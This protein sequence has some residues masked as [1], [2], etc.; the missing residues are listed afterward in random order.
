VVVLAGAD[1]PSP[2]VGVPRVTIDGATLDDP[3]EAVESLHRSWSDR[4]PVV[5]DLGVD[6]ADL[7][8]PVDHRVEPWRVDPGFEPWLDQLHFLVWANNYDARGGEPVWWWGRK[9]VEVG[10]TTTGTADVTLPDGTP[11]WVDGGPRTSRPLTDLAVVHAETVEAGR[12]DRVPAPATP[13][14]ALDPEQLAA[15]DHDSGPARVIA[16]A[17]SGKTRVLT[18]RLRHLIA[19]RGYETGGVLAVAYNKQAQLEMAARTAGLGARIQTLNAWGYS[20]VARILG[21][22]PEVIDERAVRAIVEGLVPR[23]ARRVNTD[24]Y[25]RYLEGLSLI[26]LGLRPPAQVEAEFGD[27]P[28]LADAFGPYRAALRSRGVVDFDEQVYLAVESLL[29][30]GTLRRSL[31]AEHRHL[32]VDEFQD[33]TPAHV[34]LVRLLSCPGYDVFAVGDDDQTIYSHAGADPRFLVDFD[35]FFPAATHHALEVN[36]RCPRAVTEGAG[37]LLGYNTVRVDKVIRP[38]RAVA[39]AVTGLDV[40]GH[41]P[42]QGAAAVAS[43]VAGWQG[44]GAVTDGMAVLARVQSLLLGPHVALTDAGVPVDSIVDRTVLGR[45]GARAALAYLRIATDPGRVDPADLVEVQRRP[46]RGLPQWIDRWLSR[47]RSIDDV[48]RAAERLDD[49]KVAPK[50]G[51]LADDLAALADLA[52][53]GATTRRLLSAVRDDIGL[54]SAMT[55]LDSTGVAAASHLDDLEGLLQVADLHPDPARFGEWL[56]GTLTVERTAGGV[57]LSTV[58]RVKGREW[59][60]V[61]VVGVNGGILPHRLAEGPASIEEERRILHVAI[62]RSSTQTVVLFDQT[63]PSQFL[64]ELDGTAPHRPAGVR[65]E[66]AVATTPAATGGTRPAIG[67]D[68]PVAAALKA[69]RAERAAADQVPAYVVMW[70]QHL[71]GI[72]ARRPSTKDELAGCPGIGPARLETYGDAILDV[73]RAAVGD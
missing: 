69:W 23:P 41:P 40:R 26:R 50:L 28:G 59:P 47:C 57:T 37:H 72:A 62:T 42:D 9:A 64:S 30:D 18:E 60:M 46:S 1:P 66:A 31:Q 34:L 54:G 36:H 61:A 44:D 2:W 43:L 73:I 45:L 19:D 16:P 65:Q 11:A 70:D 32:L 7:R 35:G 21:S 24:P 58:H 38:G 56:A 8:R 6:A 49:V 27:V 33:L 14:A 63:R 3:A 53:A 68:D 25:A 22:R 12:L 71:V 17:G 13:T 10:A 4:W 29:G 52:S 20:L 51:K 48:H 67:T 39:T 55:L 15:V 5:I